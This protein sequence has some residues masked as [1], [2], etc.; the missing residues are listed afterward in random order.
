[1]AF[2]RSTEF[3]RSTSFTPGSRTFD[4]QQN[5]Q[6]KYAAFDSEGNGKFPRNKTQN[7]SGKLGVNFFAS[8]H[9]R[10]CLISGCP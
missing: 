8:V 2:F 4:E 5:R 1:M 3:T 10:I 6:S 7:D 9:T